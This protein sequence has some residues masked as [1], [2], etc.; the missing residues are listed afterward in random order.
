MLFMKRSHAAKQGLTLIEVLVAL[1]I[2][3]VGA[4]AMM[5]GM[6]RCL[7]VVRTARNHEV[8]RGLIQQI[9]V[10]NPIEKVDLDEM[11][12]S[13]DFPDDPGYTWS[14]DITM[15]DPEN[16]PG[17]FLVTERVQWSERGHDTYEEV[18]KYEYAPNAKSVTSQVQS[19]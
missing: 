16:R 4:T 19:K 11:S 9:D 1:I 13:G 15:V 8:A 5:I 18:S 10:E 17:L 6:A 7:A 2:L 3:S 12:D 14:R